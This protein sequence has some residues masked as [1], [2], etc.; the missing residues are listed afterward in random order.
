MEDKIIKIEEQSHTVTV[1]TKDGMKTVCPAKTT[2][3]FYESGR[4]DCCVNIDL[5][6]DVK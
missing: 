1:N 6:G 4:K 3:T 5:Y 2:Y